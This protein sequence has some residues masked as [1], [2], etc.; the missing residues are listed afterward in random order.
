MFGSLYYLKSYMVDGSRVALIGYTIQ[1]ARRV[2]CAVLFAALAC[3]WPMQLAHTYIH[4]W[5]YDEELANISGSLQGACLSKMPCRLV[6]T[7]PPLCFVVPTHIYG[8][9]S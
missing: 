7:I 4:A 6:R 8:G 9:E 2:V 3:M 1:V 5:P